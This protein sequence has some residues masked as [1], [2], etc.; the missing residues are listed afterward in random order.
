MGEAIH[1]LRSK[2]QPDGTWLLGLLAFGVIRMLPSA[3]EKDSPTD[4]LCAKKPPLRTTH[5]IPLD[6]Q[7]ELKQSLDDAI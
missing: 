3:S 4:A 1:L 5:E 7:V 2:Q 6:H